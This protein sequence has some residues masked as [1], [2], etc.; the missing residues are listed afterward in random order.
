MKSHSSAVDP[1]SDSTG[2]MRRHFSRMIP[3]FLAGQK[4]GGVEEE[5]DIFTIEAVLRWT[6][7]GGRASTVLYA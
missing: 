2:V 4:T 1:K 7:L 6:L 3:R 5:N